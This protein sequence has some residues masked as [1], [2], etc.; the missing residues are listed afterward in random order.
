MD[1]HRTIFGDGPEIRRLDQMRALTSTSAV[2]VFSG[3]QDS[4]T[5]LFWAQRQFPEVHLITFDYRQKHRIEIDAARRIAKL[6]G[7][8]HTIVGCEFFKDL[9]TSSLLGEQR[10]QGEIGADHLPDSFVPGRNIV[11]MTLAGA[12]AYRVGAKHLVT[13]VCQTDYSGYPDCRENTMQSLAETLRLGMEAD[14]T[15]HTPLMYLTKAQSVLLAAEVGAID[16]LRYTHTCYN[17]EVPPCGS[18]PACV[19]RAKGFAEAGIEDPLL[20]RV[21]ALTE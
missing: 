1:T 2:V 21:R 16:A 15:I 4:T 9:V 5:C 8:P 11:F 14:L 7:L 6:T 18:C 19:L 12:Y 17:G 20:A 13:G 3:G 10:V